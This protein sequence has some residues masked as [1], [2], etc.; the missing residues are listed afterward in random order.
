MA[1]RVPMATIDAAWLGMED[2]TNLMMV[3]GVMALDGPVDLKRLRQMLDRRL[4]PF[5]R[6]HQLVVRPR[7]R[8]NIPHWQEDERFEIENHLS[9]VALPEPGDDAALRQ[10]VSELMSV[11]LDFGKPLW[12]MHVIDGYRGGSVIL[13][14]I[15]HSIADGIALVRVLLSLTDESPNGKPQRAAAKRPRSGFSLP[16]NW[17]ITNPSRALE[18]AR[19]GAQGAYRLG[20]MVMLPS[21]PQTLFKGELGRRKRA[22]W[23][24]PVPLVDFKAIGNAYGATVN[25]VLVATAT[26]ALRRYMEK[27]GDRTAGIAIRASVP[28]NLR[29]FDQGHKLGNAFGLVFLTLPIGIADP[30]RR[31]RAIKKEM[32]ELKGSPEALVAFGVLTLLGIAPVEVEQLGLRFF[33]SKA[34]AV[35]T[36]VP[37]PREPLFMAGRRIEK[38]MFWVPQS[39]H[40]GLGI[41]ILSYAGGVMLG[42]ATDAG[43]V[44]DPE[45]IVEAFK[46]EFD[47]L[48]KAAAKAAF[49][50]RRARSASRPTSP[51]AGR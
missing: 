4:K 44:P 29:P 32:D 26:G 5:G 8:G 27:R 2:P 15:H 3:T 30:A 37:G 16:L 21:D 35:L 13:A 39:G 10:L 25:D 51:S 1:K 31:L 40:L 50:T 18:V 14:R 36:N 20:R 17:L 23:S 48:R 41:S 34:T 7:S 11:P 46:V 24:E 9:H 22:A 28:V 19:V 45:R 43:L 38:I 42:V 12:H 33:G 49:P 6:F 47:M